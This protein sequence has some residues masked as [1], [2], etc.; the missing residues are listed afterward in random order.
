MWLVFY[1]TILGL[2]HQMSSVQRL[3]LLQTARVTSGESF[4]LMVPQVPSVLWEK[5]NLPERYREETEKPE[6]SVRHNSKLAWRNAH[7][8]NR[9]AFLSVCNAQVVSSSPLAL[10]D[11]SHQHEEELKISTF[12]LRRFIHGSLWDAVGLKSHENA[13]QRGRRSFAFN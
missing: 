1:R 7:A 10:K 3:V 2:R 8:E 11:N 12:I 6:E 9:F 13:K 4:N 5:H